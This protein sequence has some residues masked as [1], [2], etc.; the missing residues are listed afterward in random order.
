MPDRGGGLHE[1]PSRTRSS[2]LS[3]PRVRSSGDATRRP[4]QFTPGGSREPS[5]PLAGSLA[6]APHPRSRQD[7][8]DRSPTSSATELSRTACQCTFLFATLSPRCASWKSRSRRAIV[9]ATASMACVRLTPLVLDYQQTQIVERQ[10]LAD[11]PGHVARAPHHPHHRVL[12]AALGRDLDLH[13][14]LFRFPSYLPSV[15]FVLFVALPVLFVSL[16]SSFPLCSSRPRPS[17]R[18]R[19]RLAPFAPSGP[20]R[21]R[22]SAR[23]DSSRSPRPANR[24][25]QPEAG[26][27]RW[28]PAFGGASRGGRSDSR[29]EQRAPARTEAWGLARPV[30]CAELD[31][32]LERYAFPRVGPAAGL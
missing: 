9:C 32:N 6:R 3:R 30:V 11:L 21:S 29:R 14:V 24:P 13:L 22:P 2:C 5:H 23:P 17:A 20:A 8:L 26:A 7:R 12:R 16:L 4:L 15:V 28:R 1:P 18:W 25:R 19:T 10:A 31:P 27:V